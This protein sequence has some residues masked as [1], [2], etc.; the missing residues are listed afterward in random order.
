MIFTL[1]H[2]SAGITSEHDQNMAMKVVV[3][4]SGSYLPPSNFLAKHQFPLGL[5]ICPLCLSHRDCGYLVAPGTSSSC[6][7][8]G[9]CLFVEGPVKGDAQEWHPGGLELTECPHLRPA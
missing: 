5:G 4:S 8:L 6:G 3:G 1:L 2:L 9:D 7:G